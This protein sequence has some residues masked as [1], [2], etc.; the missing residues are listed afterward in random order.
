[1]RFGLRCRA[2]PDDS[3]GSAR[4]STAGHGRRGLR[5]SLLAALVSVGV[6]S[7]PA[8]AF[9]APVA[10]VFSGFKADNMNLSGVTAVAVSGT[11]AYTTAYFAGRLTAVDISNP[12]NPMVAGASPMATSLLNSTNIE[13]SGGYAYAVS[14]NRNAAQGSSSNDDGS[15]NSLTIL[16][17]HTNPA[18]PS[19]LGTLHDPVNLFGAYGIAVAN[20]FAY[21]AAQGCL[22]GQP[23]LNPAVGNSFSVV[24]VSNPLLPAAVTTLTNPTSGPNV[25]ALDHPTSVAVSNGFAYVTSSYANSL[26]VIDISN[27]SAPKIVKV[28]KDSTNLDFDVDVT[29]QGNYAY[30]ADQGAGSATAIGLAVVDI[31][32]PSLAHVVGAVNSP[33][34]SL[35]GAY[36]VKV[37]GDFAYVSASSANGVAGVDISDPLNPRLVFGLVDP[38]HLHKS[39]GLDISA[40]GQL[41]ASSPY[42]S[43]E[44][45]PLYPPFSNLTGTI[46]DITLDPSPIAVTIAPS[47]EPPAVTGQNTANFAFSAND[48]VASM[49]CSIDGAPAGLCTTPTSQQYGLLPNASHTFSV[50]ATDAAGNVATASYSWVISPAGFANTS[51]PTISG[52][53][54]EGQ[55]LVASP[56]TWIGTPAPTLAYQWRRCDSSR[57]N[58]VAIGGATSSAYTLTAADV[59]STIDVVVTGTTS[60][61]SVSATSAPTTLVTAPQVASGSTTPLGSPGPTPVVKVTTPPNGSKVKITGLAVV[62]I[63]GRYVLQVRLTKAATL[64][65]SIQRLGVGGRVTLKRFSRRLKAGSSQLV[66][67]LPTRHHTTYAVLVTARGTAAKDAASSS[68]IFKVR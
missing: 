46:S 61:G 1:L 25:N 34:Q 35:N 40:S 47:S 26:T 12:G 16:D 10:P 11:Y 14:K 19:I 36:R 32:T 64:V 29:V 66:L 7:F 52:S 38:S 27:P 67:S 24:N 33:A 21:I 53:P 45:A 59:G 48:S 68:R 39:T 44:S 51:A 62:R 65:V 49:R 57:A 13:I 37:R 6:L 3:A 9:A 18:L 41:I 42:L 22:S 60:G 55:P 30:V 58:C 28:L 4:A 15:G 5:Q 17:I 56:G 31:S 8:A 23:C 50:Q 20:G 63:H 2:L 43:T 54:L